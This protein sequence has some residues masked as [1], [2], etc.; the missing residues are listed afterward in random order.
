MNQLKYNL[1]KINILKKLHSLIFTLLIAFASCNQSV[2]N[3]SNKRPSSPRIRKNVSLVSPKSNSSYKV[4]SPLQLQIKHKDEGGKI[5]SAFALLDNKSYTFSE[6]QLLIPSLTTVGKQKI[7][8]HAYVDG[9]KESLYPNVVVLPETPPTQYSY[10]ILETYPHDEAA[11]TQGLFFLEDQ[12]FE[13]TGQLGESSLRKVEFQTGK[14]QR[15]MNMADAYFGEGSTVW[16][17][18]IFF[19]TWT[20]RIG[21]VYDLDFNSLRSFNYPT[22]GWGL[23]TYGDTLIMSDGT[24]QLY[25]INPRDFSTLKTVQVYD[26]QGKV[27][28]LNELEMIDGLLYANVWGT[29]K[30]VIIDPNTGIVTGTI[31]FSGLFTGYRANKY[32]KSLNGIAVDNSGAIFV[33]GKLWPELYKISITP[34]NNPI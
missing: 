33:T 5:D 2:E 1:R 34:K 10:R 21:F 26:H 7:Q 15:M 20:S 31:D 22:E 18:Q 28:E 6:N 30:I 9:T 12:L 4:G 24:E 8:I 23:T 11:W 25:F 17:D 16:N 3:Q 14:V 19:L 13:T 27:D 32:D 29:E